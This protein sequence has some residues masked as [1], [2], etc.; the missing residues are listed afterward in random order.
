MATSRILKGNLLKVSK[1]L[2][3]IPSSA[4]NVRVIGQIPAPKTKIDASHEDHRVVY[5]NHLL[6]MRPVPCAV[7][8]VTRMTNHLGNQ[9]AILQSLPSISREIPTLEKN[10][11]A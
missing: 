11:V 8:E 1:E 10:C 7:S 3:E 9:N 5:H 6:V 2:Q 4:P